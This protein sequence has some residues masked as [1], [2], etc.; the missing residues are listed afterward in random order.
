MV[1]LQQRSD[2]QK[3]AQDWD[4]A[5]ATIREMAA[6]DPEHPKVY[7][8]IVLV[9]DR[10]GKR[11]A[12]TALMDSL[13]LPHG[14]GR[15]YG[16]AVAS[17]I[18]KRPDPA[19]RAFSKALQQYRARGH[20]AGQAACHFGLGRIA[21]D[22]PNPNEAIKQYD[23]A[24][25]L[26][27]R[28][29]DVKGTD[30][31]L[32]ETAKIAANQ[33]Q[34]AEA[35][36]RYRESL[37]FRDNLGDKDGQA[38]C[39]SGIGKSLSAMGDRE[40]ALDA[41]D[42]ALAI[43]REIKDWKGELSTLEGVAG[44]YSAPADLDKA[45]QALKDALRIAEKVPDALSRAEALRFQGEALLAAGHNR[46]A[47]DPLEEAAPIYKELKDVRFEGVTLGKLGL[48]LNRVGEFGRARAV[49][50]R[51]LEL[52][53]ASTTP[54]AEAAALS[55]LGTAY[56][57]TGEPTRALVVQEQSV[58]L[59]RKLKDAGGELQALNS[60]SMSYFKMG[61]LDRSRSY[62]LKT[63]KGYESLHDRAG[64]ARS[65]SN[66]GVLL[67]EENH[68]AEG[69]V[70]IRQAIT[71]R[72]E[73]KD[74]RGTAIS[75]VSGAETL[76]RLGRANDALPLLQEA[77]GN[78]RANGDRGTDAYALNVLGETQIALRKSD[79]ALQSHRL[80]LAIAD[81]SGLAEERWRAHAGI[82][83]GLEAQGK[84]DAAFEETLKAI[85]EVERVRKGLIVGEFKMRY[86][87][88]KVGLYES[89]LARLI[90]AKTDRVDASVV[91]RS[92]QLAE[93]AQARSLLDL[94]SE[95]RA[96][97][98]E[99][100]PEE[101]QR[102]E[103][104]VL[105]DL[106]A[107]SVQLA[108]DETSEERDA[109]RARVDASRSKLEELEIAIH[110]D[111]PRYGALL[112]PRPITLEAVQSRVLREDEVLLEYFLGKG[113][114]WLW[115]I[116]KH[117]AA[118]RD[119]GQSSEIVKRT[120]AFLDQATSMAPDR[121]SA[122]SDMDAAARLS[123]AILPS[124]AI[125]AGKRLVI[126][127]DGPLRA[128]PFETLRRDG[129]YLVEERETVMAPSAAVIGLMRSDPPPVAAARFLGVGDPVVGKA[130]K[131]DAKL[132]YARAELEA[133]AQTFPED[134]RTLLLGP[135]ATRS[136]LKKVSLDQN[137][138]IL[139][140]THG[141]IDADPRYSGL[142]LSPAA[143][144]G[145]LDVLTADD[146]VSLSLASEI[147]VLSACRSGAGEQ[148]AGEGT[149]GL[150]RAFLYAGSRSA[151]VSL[152]DVGDRSTAVFMSGFFEKMQKGESAPEALRHEKLEFL[153]SDRAARRRIRAW[154]PFVLVGD[155][156]EGMHGSNQA[157]TRATH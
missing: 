119:L 100:M 97:L 137:R 98:R 135:E 50:E 120:R 52:S 33:G 127:A 145:P 14:P 122:P 140:S 125:P 133:A 73:L 53:R 144:G 107:A 143:P 152:W 124:G 87:A 69:L 118:L 35:L 40:G 146:I 134:Q 57:A 6:L 82:A 59:C 147:V 142:K 74:S 88:G 51:A 62:I 43:R 132:L 116:D 12:T 37:A 93:R 138:Y 94:L 28:L 103:Q 29:K 75:C 117:G 25:V 81:E 64:I 3:N 84:R 27:K 49:L 30:D 68:P 15:I 18:Q 72:R 83:S 48:A 95:S 121:A 85:D 39:W 38:R 16:E 60:L 112:Y 96:H 151:L 104:D 90:P 24:A 91:A 67:T 2:G 34:H 153:K 44:V 36:R 130:P 141:W 47:L 136:E 41:F 109:S 113:H 150:A 77:L 128:L 89:A 71:I 86:L 54:I 79:D 45:L 148:L 4:G 102:Q 157:D 42:H 32:Q 139:F 58:A 10:R 13:D 55:D 99:K 5:T 20:I 115:V 156:G 19:S 108:E 131:A 123:S 61:I 63:L 8:Q 105:D 23:A 31:L 70:Q 155:P 114:A 80:A 17:L 26:L 66:L 11:E 56:L 65:R 76:L 46:E 9:Q 106:S 154:A 126:V 149:V 7:L 21:K 110:R 111:A 101:L 129:R 1:A 22:V 92:F 78:A